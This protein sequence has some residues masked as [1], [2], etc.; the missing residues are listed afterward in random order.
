MIDLEEIRYDGARPVEGYGPDFFRI[1]GEVLRGHVL[2]T[3]EAARLW[4]GPEDIAPLD[5]L[6]GKV[7]V[8]LYGT[9]ATMGRAP[10]A[11]VAALDAKGIGVEA[12]ASDAAARTYNV[13]VSEGRRVAAALLTVG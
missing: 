11:L 4:R 13:L 2:V 9:G 12:M 3:A 8:L 10:A 6:A 5:G 7:D 1:G